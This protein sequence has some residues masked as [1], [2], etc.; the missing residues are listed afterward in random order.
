MAPI[1]PPNVTRLSWSGSGHSCHIGGEHLPHLEGGYDTPRDGYQANYCRGRSGPNIH[2]GIES[3][4]A[5]GPYTPGRDTF[6][7][8]E[9]FVDPGP[10]LF[11]AKIWPNERQ[12]EGKLR[13]FMLLTDIE[14]IDGPRR[15]ARSWVEMPMHASLIPSGTEITLMAGWAVHYAQGAGE[16]R[17]GIASRGE[18]YRPWPEIQAPW[19]AGRHARV[20]TQIDELL[21]QLGEESPWTVGIHASPTWGEA[22]LIEML[23]RFY[24][25]A[26]VPRPDLRR[27]GEV[28]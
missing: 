22:S 14:Q 26:G 3:H 18:C 13:G 19:D 24:D 8:W 27:L 5:G 1:F 25:S 16:W 28:P 10:F 23:Y 17:E 2:I 7:V 21:G 15:A 11:R 4:R 12:T 20:V 9:G 6:L